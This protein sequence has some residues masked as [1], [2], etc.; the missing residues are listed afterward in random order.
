M[1]KYFSLFLSMLL[2]LSMTATPVTA[3]ED[4][5]NNDAPADIVS[6]EGM[7]ESSLEEENAENVSESDIEPNEGVISSGG[8]KMYQSL[9]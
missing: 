8:P 2:I 7:T 3:S 1:K 5:L 9:I 4:I 6:I